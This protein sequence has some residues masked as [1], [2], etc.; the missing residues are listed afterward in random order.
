MGRRT[1]SPRTSSCPRSRSRS[2]F[3]HTFKVQEFVLNEESA[4]ALNAGDLST[5]RATCPEVRDLS[6]LLARTTHYDGVQ[7]NSL[8]EQFGVSVEAMA[9]RLE[10]LNLI[11]R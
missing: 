8:A 10:E 9:I 5:L 2:A 3:E 4:F 6:R 7:I 11:A 1:F